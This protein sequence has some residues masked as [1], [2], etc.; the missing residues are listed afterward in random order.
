[1]DSETLKRLNTYRG[2]KPGDEPRYRQK[3]GKIKKSYY[4]APEGDNWRHADSNSDNKIEGLKLMVLKKFRFWFVKDEKI[5]RTPKV[6]TP[7]VVIKETKKKKSPPR[8]EDEPGMPPI[9]VIKEGV[10][11]LKISFANYETLSTAPGAQDA[12]KTGD[13]VE[14]SGENVKKTFVEGEVHTDS[15][16]TESDF[17]PTKIAPTSYVSG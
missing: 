4:V 16:E 3:F 14:A 11:L 7:K 1:M 12:V 17:D 9:D 13:N 8:L 6:S 15:S 10:D 5:K 2:V